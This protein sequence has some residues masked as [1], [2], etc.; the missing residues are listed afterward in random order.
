MAI[1]KKRGKVRGRYLDFLRLFERIKELLFDPTKTWIVAIGLLVAEI[2]VNVGI[3][4]KIKCEYKPM[5]TTPHLVCQIKL[6]TAD[7]FD[8]NDK[9]NFWGIE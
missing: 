7:Q 3:I 1:L 6:Q 4:W 2:V 5:S 8:L 9:V